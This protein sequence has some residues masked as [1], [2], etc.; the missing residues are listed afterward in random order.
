MIFKDREEAG[1][2]LAGL[3]KKKFSS[4][5]KR[6]QLVVVSLLRGGVV[7]GYEIAKI[8]DIP[9]K[10]LAVVKISTPGN[11]ELAIGALCFDCIYLDDV[12]IKL[13]D[14]DKRQIEI[15]IE[16]AKEKFNSYINRFSVSKEKYIKELKNKKIILVDDGVAT[17]ATVKAASLFLKSCPIKAVYLASPVAPADF[18][19]TG[20][21]KT[22]ILSI[23][24][25]L[26]A[27][28]QFYERFPQVED[29][30]VTAYFSKTLP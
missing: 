22:F 20:F 21:D 28:S 5:A 9:H 12:L 30:D 15:Q 26:S 17:G 1:I 23:E 13:L 6:K 3:L 27:I 7:I 10:P 29:N 25:H 11:P 14:L 2:K 4:P 19:T 18:Q 24:P 8:L 16:K